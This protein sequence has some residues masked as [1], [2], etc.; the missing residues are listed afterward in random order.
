MLLVPCFVALASTAVQAQMVGGRVI[1]DSTRRPIAGVEVRLI[2]SATKQPVDSARTDS[3]GIF[4][5][6]A[7]KP[8]TY[9][10]MLLRE[11]SVPRYSSSWTLATA[12]AFQQGTFVLPE[13]IERVA[14]READVD[15]RVGMAANNPSPRYPTTLREKK[16]AG[17]VRIRFIV[18]STGHLLPGTVRV[19]YS[20][21]PEFAEAVEAV[22]G[23]WK[24][25]PAKKNGAAV[26][27][28]AC[29]PM[30]FRL[31]PGR[32]TKPLDAQFDEWVAHPTCP[33]D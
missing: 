21:A 2:D 12:E 32:D 31:D 5:T 25:A 9:S 1:G 18:D 26:A 7:P 29:M 20:T 15:V 8:G 30:T 23:T 33:T 4:Y 16:V 11:R 13:G 22:I 17:N 19:L 6:T 24:F 27:Q 28:I 3:A 10:L 14:Y